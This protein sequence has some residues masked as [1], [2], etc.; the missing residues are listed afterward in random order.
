[1][2]ETTSYYLPQSMSETV[3]DSLLSPLSTVVCILVCTHYQDGEEEELDVVFVENTN[4]D[5][6]AIKRPLPVDDVST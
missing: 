5:M 4:T 1:M 6:A 3:T 2:S